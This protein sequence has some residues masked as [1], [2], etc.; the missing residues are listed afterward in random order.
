MADELRIGLTELLR[1][2]MIEHDA[3]FLKEGVRALSQAIMEMEVEEHIGAARHERTEGRS[4]HRNG[5]RERTWDTRAGAIELK[6]PRVRDSSYFPSL[7]EPR[8]RAERALSAVVQEAYVHGIS[9]RKVDELVKALGMGGISKSQVSRLCEELDE[10]VERF[11]NRPLEGAYPYVWVDA[12]YVMK[13]RQ[14]GRV[15]SV[16]MVIAVGVKGDTG[17]RE[18]LGLDVGPSEDGAFWTAFLRSLVARGLSGVRLVTSDA[19]RGLKSAIEK[20]LQ[21]ASWQRCRV[22]FMRNALSLV[23]KAAQQMVGATIRTVFA[24][25]D[26]ESA[27][28]QWRRVA[29]GFRPR[30]PKLAELMDGAEEDVLAYA[31]FPS[32]HW[33]KVWSNN[34]LE[35]LNKE[36]KRRTNVVGIFPNEAAV[37]RLVGAVLS[38]QHDEW[39]VVGKRY[40]GVGSLAKLERKEEA[41]IE[42]AELM[43]G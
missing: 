40:F 22:H 41:V 25:P 16:A 13:S 6:V 15:V 28:E 3:D 38:E 27:R 12:T 8:R 32:E 30:F 10:E 4:G 7:L 18:V 1:K 36:V 5:Y 34:P 35:R 20:V 2:A 37:V 11:R 39:Q 33:Q 42:Q 19:H 17:E 26:G 31:A 9:T 14:D 23:P 21:G 43:A 29:D 24:Q